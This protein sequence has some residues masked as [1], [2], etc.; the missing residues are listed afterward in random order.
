MRSLLFLP[1]SFVLQAPNFEQSERVRQIPVIHESADGN[2][3][4]PAQHMHNTSSHSAQI[5]IHH[6]GGRGGTP[7]HMEGSYQHRGGT[8]TRGQYAGGGAIP[9]HMRS[10][11][12][13]QPSPSLSP[14]SGS[15]QRTIPIRVERGDGD[16]ADHHQQYAAEDNGGNRMQQKQGGI[17][18]IPVQRERPQPQQGN[19]YQPQRT[20]ERAS[21]QPQATYQSSPRLTPRMAGA[22]HADSPSRQSPAPGEQPRASP[23]PTHLR[24]E[25]PTPQRAA[26]PALAKM[27]PI[28]QIHVIQEESDTLQAKINGFKGTKGSKEYR[29]LEEM[30]TRLLLKL[31]GIESE[32]KDEIRQARKQ[33]IKSVQAGLDHL[34]LLVMANEV[35]DEPRAGEAPMESDAPQGEEQSNEQ[36]GGPT[37][38][39]RVKEVEM[40]SEVKC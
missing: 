13:R 4:S 39:S 14:K 1:V 9:H 31:D 18:Q 15:P 35:S 34:E 37:N 21:P 19:N 11:G 29:Y 27:S 10:E 7:P 12:W 22:T 38:E 36:S 40:D 30:L 26:S 23:V 2:Q 6:M 8:P 3:S 20:H 5:P 17:Q 24:T 33:A 28:E 32:G 16:Q 25:S